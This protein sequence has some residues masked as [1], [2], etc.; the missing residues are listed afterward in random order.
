MPTSRLAIVASRG[1]VSGAEYLRAWRKGH[2]IY[3]NG[4]TLYRK[5]GWTPTLVTLSRKLAS[6]P[7]QYKVEWVKGHAGHPLNELAD[8]MAKPALRTLDGYFSRGEAVDLARRYAHRA[9]SEISM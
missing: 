6:D 5:S 8:S 9:L 1:R 2:L 4:Y 7:R 3:S